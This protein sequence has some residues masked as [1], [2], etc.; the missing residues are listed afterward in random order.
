MPILYWVVF[1]ILGAFFGPMLLAKFAGAKA[2]A[3]GGY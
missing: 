2:P 3:G 1:G